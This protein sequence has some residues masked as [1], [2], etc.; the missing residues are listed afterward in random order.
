M[1]T[2][3]FSITLSLLS[4]IQE[5]KSENQT[6][7]T[8]ANVKDTIIAKQRNVLIKSYEVDF[9]SK[10]YSY[11]WIVGK[12]TLDFVLNATEHKKDST[13]HLNIHHKR[14][15][16]FYTTLTRISECIPLIREEFYISKFKSI[17]F[18][19]PIYYLDLTKELS[20]EYEK[21]FGQKYISYKKLNQFLL[22]S[23]PNKNLNGFVNSLD[24]K[25]KRYSI[26]KF[27]LTEKK[28]YGGYLT[29]VDLTEYPEFAIN[30]MGLYLE[31]ENK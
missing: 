21:Q 7:N 18:R 13:L 29:G 17:Y 1:F 15:I 3:L 23:K 9:Y 11:Y 28:Y 25:V 19:N 30:G 6:E 5:T 31:L 26:E 22:N 4:C 16:F 24:K 14:P 20:S 10:A 12:D 8:S 2:I 27:Q